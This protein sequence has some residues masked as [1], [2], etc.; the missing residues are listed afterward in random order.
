MKSASLR[1]AILRVLNGNDCHS[2]SAVIFKEKYAVCPANSFLSSDFSLAAT[3]IL[4]CLDRDQPYT[5]Y[6]DLASQFKELQC[7]IVP[8]G[9][10]KE[11]PVSLKFIFHSKVI[12]S[13]F[14]RLLSKSPS[15]KLSKDDTLSADQRALLLSSFLVFQFTENPDPDT[16][17]ESHAPPG[18]DKDFWVIATPYGNSLMQGSAFKCRVANVINGV[19]F[20][21]DQPL[22]NGCEGGLLLSPLSDPLGM[23]LTTSFESK[24]ENL[25][26]TFAGDLREIMQGLRNSGEAIKE[27]LNLLSLPVD[28]ASKFV[29]LLESGRNSYGTGTL[30][31]VEKRR[32]ILTC[33]HVVTDTRDNF[34]T[35][36]GRRYP[37]RLIYKNPIFDRPFD[38]AVFE[39]PVKI[40][41][42]AFCTSSSSNPILGEL[43]SRL[44]V[45]RN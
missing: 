43:G 14:E 44:L 5:F 18:G 3:T 41:S 9:G 26:L 4:R 33:S 36:K 2:S 31:R 42:S 22:S 19:L 35:W 11:V 39:A 28:S 13:S 27:E 7:S 34:C 6:D 1:P 20:L 40:P 16:F 24:N 45:N 23:I 8:P 30:I 37:I 12:R 21:I 29:V 25:N 10:K 15:I 17:S 32:L 38:V